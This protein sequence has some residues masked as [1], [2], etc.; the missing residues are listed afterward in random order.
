MDSPD[1]T[2]RASIG[3]DEEKRQPQPAWSLARNLRANA[4]DMVKAVHFEADNA[5]IPA[6]ASRAAGGAAALRRLSGRV[7]K[8]LRFFAALYRLDRFSRP[9]D[10]RVIPCGRYTLRSS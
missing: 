4:A 2:G 8:L 7:I 9:E 5:A 3:L 10:I 6:P 1:R